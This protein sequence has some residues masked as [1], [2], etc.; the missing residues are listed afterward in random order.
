[1]N[2]LIYVSL[3]LAF[4]LCSCPKEK[5]TNINV[6]N[7]AT[8]SKNKSVKNP[9]LDKLFQP[10]D[11]NS[12]NTPAISNVAEY[13][14]IT[15]INDPI[16]KVETT[17]ISSDLVLD[18]FLPI[19]QLILDK[20]GGAAD[21]LRLMQILN[22]NLLTQLKDAFYLEKAAQYKQ[23]NSKSD[24]SDAAGLGAVAYLNELNKKY[25]EDNG[26]KK[27]ETEVLIDLNKSKIEIYDPFFLC[28]RALDG[29][30]D[31]TAEARSSGKDKI[32]EVAFNDIRKVTFPSKVG[33]MIT[34]YISGKPRFEAAISKAKSLMTKYP[35]DFRG[36][37]FLSCFYKFWQQNPGADKPKISSSEITKLRKQGIDFAFNLDSS[38]PYIQLEMADVLLSLGNKTEANKFLEMAFKNPNTGLSVL[39]ALKVFYSQKLDNTNKLIEVDKAMQ[40]FTKKLDALKKPST[41]QSK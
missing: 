3:L 7:K 1:M 10:E 5:T 33:N 29:D 32:P 38:N 40:E 8:V 27:R 37:Y 19:Y 4:S 35:N 31:R 17:T 20:E 6:D 41:Q 12:P 39:D 36:G 2:R 24:R 11:S 22:V 30:A 13:P 16:G 14:F 15:P 9:E 26:M 28:Y 34:V 25:G 23:I 21:P 18:E